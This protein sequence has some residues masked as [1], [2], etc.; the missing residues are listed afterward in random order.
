M[1][2]SWSLLTSSA[3]KRVCTVCCVP[4]VP[5][6]FTQITVSAFILALAGS[7][8]RELRALK[9]TADVSP[10]AQE[11]ARGRE[12][13]GQVFPALA[14]G[15]QCSGAG[16]LSSGPLQIQLPR[17]VERVEGTV[18]SQTH[19]H[20]CASSCCFNLSS[21]TCSQS[22]LLFLPTLS[23]VSLTSF[24]QSSRSLVCFRSGTVDVCST[25]D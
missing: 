19:L 3:V 16:T 17:D 1:G 20:T 8:N 25:L 9:L 18:G 6:A 24:L 14:D 22:V 23:K 2:W 15:C 11:A 7:S 21:S 12:S 4:Y 13:V 5:S 10:S